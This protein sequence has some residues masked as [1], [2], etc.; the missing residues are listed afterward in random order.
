MNLTIGTIKFCNSINN[1]NV[2]SDLKV[3]DSTPKNAKESKLPNIDYTNQYHTKDSLKSYIL[4]KTYSEKDFSD[5][6]KEVRQRGKQIFS[7]NEF[8]IRMTDYKKNEQWAKEMENL[9]YSVSFAI[10]NGA[11]F[12]TILKYLENGIQFIHKTT[13][14]LNNYNSPFGEKRKMYH[15]LGLSIGKRGCEYINRYYEKS[16]TK[17]TEFEMLGRTFEMYCPKSNQEYKDANVAKIG[18]ISQFSPQNK[19]IGVCQDSVD[20][21]TI[22]NL[23]FVKKEFEKLS[24][25]ENPTTQDVMRSCAIIQWLIAQETPYKRGS[26]SVANVLTKAIMHAYNI[27]ISPVKEGISL[28]FEAFDTDLDDY[29]KKYPDFFEEKPYKLES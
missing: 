12:E 24:Q 6:K 17:N 26:D 20:K 4:A 7:G 1:K 18:I 23:F 22:S 2:Q 5:I 19:L 25:I 15:C 8:F 28:D 9:T 29:I 11:S 10:S 14:K 21:Y 3:N 16:K 13:P 27:H